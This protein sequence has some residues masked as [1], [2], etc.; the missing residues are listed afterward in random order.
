MNRA[1]YQHRVVKD[2]STSFTVEEKVEE[3]DSYMEACKL[4]DQFNTVTEVQNG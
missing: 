1:D 3:A 2:V 4:A